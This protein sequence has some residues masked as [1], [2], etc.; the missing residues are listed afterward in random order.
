M[1]S[2]YKKGRRMTGR[3]S[4]AVIRRK[5][6]S[7]F[8]ILGCLL[9]FSGMVSRFELSR[10]NRTTD[11]LITVSVRDLELSQ[12]MFDAIELQ[13]DAMQD[14]VSNVDSLFQIGQAGFDHAFREAEQQKIY[15]ARLALIAEAKRRYDGVLQDTLLR[16]G[17]EYRLAW[18]E[19]ALAIKD[20]MIDNQNT[21]D[22]NTAQVQ[23]NAYRALMPGV[24]TLLV[25]IGIIVIFYFMIDLYY[26]GPVI[27]VSRALDNYLN[28]KVPYAVK[29]DGRD[30]VK[31]LSEQIETLISGIGKKD[32]NP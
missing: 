22:S 26:I 12:A 18:H 11:T 9:L 16:N 10:L 8:I 31:T 13:R 5:I 19:L 29:L 28:L 6:R 24:I 7:G 20:F 27:R 4:V 25:A 14:G 21:V 15:P 30:E 3:Q 23:A 32:N 17:L 1:N 2:L